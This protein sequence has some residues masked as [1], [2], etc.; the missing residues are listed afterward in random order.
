MCAKFPRSNKANKY[1][2]MLFTL[3][4]RSLPFWNNVQRCSLD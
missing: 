4:E 2:F 1:D 3:N